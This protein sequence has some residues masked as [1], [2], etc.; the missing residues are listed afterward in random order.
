MLAQSATIPF[1]VEAT[2]TIVSAVHGR[3]R[4][5]SAWPPQQS[6]TRTPSRYTQTEAPTSP[7]SVK[8]RKNSSRTAVKRGS[9]CPSIVSIGSRGRTWR[10][11]SG[12]VVA[13]RLTEAADLAG[14]Q[15]GEA[16]RGQVLEV[17]PD[18]L[19]ADRQSLAR[20]AHREGGGG[21]ARHRGE[22]RVAEPVQ[23]RHRP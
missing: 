4:A 8:F 13:G 11:S 9:Q 19:E 7:R 10:S 5:G 23:V 15:R 22:R 21:L 20:E 6:T 12:C 2:L 3:E 1:V 14:Q 18:R 17:G 16:D